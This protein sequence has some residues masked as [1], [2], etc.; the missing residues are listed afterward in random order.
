VLC[1][2]GFQDGYFV[3]GEGGAGGSGGGSAGTGT[4]GTAMGGSGGGGSPGVYYFEGCDDANVTPGDGCSETCTVEDGFVCD[5]PGQPCREPRCGDGFIDFV[6]GG[7]GGGG[8]GGAGGSGMGGFGGSGMSGSYEQCDDGN[9]S[10]SDGCNATCTVE[11]G[12]ACW[13]PGV[14]CHPI[15]CGDE[16]VDWPEEQCD[17]GNT[18]P[19]DGCT[20][21]TYDGGFGGSGGM[22]TGGTGFTGGS[23]GSFMGG[24]GF[25]G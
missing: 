10:A 13:E 9:T 12:F 20:N 18:I 14:P 6:P 4:G 17:D 16:L 3:P 22:G 1:G 15:V 19:N 8:A 7:G 25:G 23:A 21:C 2:D 24:A 11:P 5:Y